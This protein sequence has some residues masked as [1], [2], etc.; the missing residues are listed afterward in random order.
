[1]GLGPLIQEQ[2]LPAQRAAQADPAVTGPQ[3]RTA[4]PAGRGQPARGVR[5]LPPQATARAHAQAEIRLLAHQGVN[6]LL[7]ARPQTAYLCLAQRDLG[8]LHDASRTATELQLSGPTATHPELGQVLDEN[9]S[10]LQRVR[11]SVSPKLRRQCCWRLG[12]AR[13][14]DWCQTSVRDWRA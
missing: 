6:A 14:G 13:C 8:S 3:G 5:S 1:M 12:A 9:R 10:F 7:L 4:A 11:G 2:A